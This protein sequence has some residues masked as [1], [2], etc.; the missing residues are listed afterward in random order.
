MKVIHKMDTNV[1]TLSQPDNFLS[2]N[3]T[4][5]HMAHY[6]RIKAA[7]EAKLK[8]MQTDLKTYRHPYYIYYEDEGEIV[9][10]QFLEK[11]IRLMQDDLCYL[12]EEYQAFVVRNGMQP[13]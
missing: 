10:Y 4:R 7:K 5:R 1:P 6:K 12:D 8:Q 13:T 9:A 2:I 3:K 11:K